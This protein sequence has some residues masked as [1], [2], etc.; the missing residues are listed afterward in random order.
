MKKLLFTLLFLSLAVAIQSQTK[1]PRYEL[2]R[3]S[4]TDKERLISHDSYTLSFNLDR[5]TPTWVAWC[6]T[7]SRV[8]GNVKRTDFFDGDPA[9]DAKYRVVHGDY[10]NSGFDRG[11]MCPAADNRHSQ[12]AMVQCFYMT[13]M[14]PQSHALN[15]GGWNDLEIQCRSWAKNYGRLYICAGPIYDGKSTLRRI[16][17]RRSYRIAV[18]DRFYKV[19]LMV[20]AKTTKAIGFIYPNASANRDIRYYAVSVDEVERLTGLDFF[21]QLDDAVEKRVEAECKPAAWGI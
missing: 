16:G 15:V 8:N 14:C 9:V 18:P 6:L 13:N 12:R 3:Q 20:G 10:Y 2:P 19:V 7:P 1:A 5:L 11:H 17:T 4:K 21:Y